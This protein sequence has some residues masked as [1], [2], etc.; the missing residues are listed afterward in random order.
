MKKLST[1]KLVGTGIATVMLVLC[2][3]LLAGW[4]YESDY[5]KNRGLEHGYYGKYN[6]VKHVLETMPDVQIV[7]DW[8]HKDISL[9]D[10]GFSILVNDSLSVQINFPDDSYQKNLHEKSKIRAYIRSRISEEQLIQA[11]GTLENEQAIE[12]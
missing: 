3:F 9:E 7:G 4:I 2:F 10:F 6:R 11:T 8:L 5:T 12:I 1:L